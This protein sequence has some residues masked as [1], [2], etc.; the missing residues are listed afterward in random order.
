MEYCIVYL[1]SSKGLLDE[2][3]LET[4]L[5]QSR[6]KNS[7]LGITGVLLYYDGSIIQALEGSEEKVKA[8][9]E[10]ISRDR[11]H[12][13]IV[14]MIS[15][16]V[17]KKVFGDWSMAFKAVTAAQ[18]DYLSQLSKDQQGRPLGAGD[19]PALGL[20]HSFYNANFRN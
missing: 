3:E 19:S 10:T 20:I 18:L 11:R 16:R 6:K 8:L 9:F 5:E 4:I 13:H 17:E 14:K 2:E 1:S 7:Q 12:W 15:Q